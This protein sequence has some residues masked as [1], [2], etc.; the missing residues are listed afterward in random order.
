VLQIKIKRS[1]RKGR[2]QGEPNLN[3]QFP[4]IGKPHLALLISNSPCVAY[5][6][7]S[8]ALSRFEEKLVEDNSKSA[9]KKLFRSEAIPDRKTLRFSIIRA[10]HWEVNRPRHKNK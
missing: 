9:A 6:Q 2:K 10:A 7:V 1:E 4:F 3:N 8:K 5:I